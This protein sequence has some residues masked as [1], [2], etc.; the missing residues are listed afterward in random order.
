MRPNGDLHVLF[1]HVAYQFDEPFAARNTGM[2][3]SVARSFDE[4]AA[5]L[6]DA[7]VLSVSMM[8]KNELAPAAKKLRLIQSISAGTD[9]YDRDVLRTHGIRLSSGQGVNANAVAEHAIACM[10]ALSR[11]LHRLRDHQGAAHWRPMQGDRRI[12]EDEIAG[13]TVLIVGLGGIG[14]RLSTLCKAFGMTVLGTRR[15]PAKGGGAAD[16]IHADAALMTLIP[17][18]D[19][20]VLTTA[21]TP[22]TAGLFGREQLAAMKPTAFLL[23]V[24]RGKVCDELALTAAL[25]ANLIAGAALDVTTEEPLAQTSPLWAMPHVIITPHSAGETVRYEDRVI[26]LLLENVARLQ[27]GEQRLVN[28]IV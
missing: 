18:A 23:N 7:D 21:L 27:R 12:R 9:Q 24:A 25:S 6:P 3:F 17:R 14:R 8:W 16:E 28:E 10:L 13:K 15:D 20:I 2:R 4:L 22:E 11:Q 1:A 5:K 19:F 26:D